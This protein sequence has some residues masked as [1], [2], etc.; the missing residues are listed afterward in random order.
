MP[1]P[2][3]GRAKRGKVV[4]VYL[5]EDLHAELRTTAE[6]ERRSVS[7]QALLF[8]EIGL[9]GA[10]GSFKK[11]SRVQPSRSVAVE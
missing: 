3:G 8:I 10:K 2:R 1:R 11:V 5:T 6:R 9:Q 4:A 7:T